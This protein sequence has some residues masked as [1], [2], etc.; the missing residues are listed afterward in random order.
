MG[1]LA[2]LLA[3]IL[4]SFTSIFFAQASAQLGS[5][6]VNRMRL[7]FAV[8]FLMIAHLILRGTPFPFDAGPE[9]WFWFGISGMVGLVF[10]DAC[11]LQ[12]YVLVGARLGTLMMATSPV[13]GTILAWIFLGEKLAVVEIAAIAVTVLGVSIVVLERGSV[14]HPKPKAY[15]LGLL[16]GL[17]GAA[18]QA[19]GLILAKIGLQ[20]NYPSISGTV[21]RMLVAMSFMWLLALVTRQVRPTFR[22]VSENRQALRFIILGA[23]F[24]PFMGVW[25]SLASVQATYVGVASTLMSLT[26]ILVLPILR[27]WFKEHISWRAVLGTVVALSGVTLLLI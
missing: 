5:V 2:A 23:M 19:G 22:A 1:E 26:P 24:G 27:F 3:A 13:I 21:M 20:G 25:L 11:L 16:F 17:G 9:R 14:A 8:I 12:C 18:G 7:G 6:K 4:W 15:A 10:G